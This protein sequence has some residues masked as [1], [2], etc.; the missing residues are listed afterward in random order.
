[1]QQRRHVAITPD[2]AKWQF[3]LDSFA[4]R[5]GETPASGG[6]LANPDSGWDRSLQ[7]QFSGASLWS[8]SDLHFFSTR[9]QQSRDARSLMLSW[10]AR[11]PL[12]GAW[13][14]GPLV[15]AERR[16]RFTD[17]SNQM[18]YTPGCVSTTRVAHRSRPQSWAELSSRELPPT[19]KAS[20][21]LSAGGLSLSVLS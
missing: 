8:S 18:L 3:M 13:R 4:L 21:A 7:L 12:V 19:M 20:P 6:V 16:E 10:S 5:I 14:L 9:Y 2:R 11:F 15:R 17:Q 1:L